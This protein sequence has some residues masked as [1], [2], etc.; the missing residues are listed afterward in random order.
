MVANKG[1]PFFT[2]PLVSTVKVEVG[3]S[4]LLKLPGLGDPDTTDIPSVMLIDFGDVAT[5]FV[6]GKY[7]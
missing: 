2:T 5:T 4:Y 6:N 1:P 7:P 3:A